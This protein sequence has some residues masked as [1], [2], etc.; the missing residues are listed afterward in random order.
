M[1]TPK[2]TGKAPAQY[3]S[4]SRSWVF[5]LN[6]YTPIQHACMLGFPFASY[7]C[8]GEEISPSGT[9]HLQGYIYLP[10]KKSLRQ[11]KAVCPEAHFEIAK[12]TPLQAANYCKKGD[13]PH[14]EW[15][16]HGINGPAFGR[17]AKFQEI[18]SAPATQAEKGKRG[19]EKIKL[20]WELAKQGK[21]EGILPPGQVK[22]WEYIHSKFGSTAT[23]RASLDNLWIM[24]KSGCGKSRFV[25]DT[26]PSF[27]SKP[28][29]KW[30]DG[31]SNEDVVVLDDFDPKHGEFLGYFLKIWADH[32]VFNAEVKGGMLR[33]RP[34]TVVVTSQ[35]S[36][37]QCFP[38]SETCAAVTRRFT[39]IPMGPGLPLPVRP[40]LVPGF[41]PGPAPT[42]GQIGRPSVH[43]RPVRPCAG[44]GSVRACAGGRSQSHSDHSESDGDSE[45]SDGISLGSQDSI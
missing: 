22:T 31:Y 5:T 38:D 8:I 40:S 37:A 16:E 2:K 36:I 30:W 4:Q 3:S 10:Q 26:F 20:M 32:Y 7:V 11:M 42:P 1:S 27:Y 41:D 18:G 35:Y 23:D 9:P 28:M 29:S 17:N 44:G 19:A 15:E 39:V 13:Q 6:N 25:R 43:H 45:P 24:G 12:G 33:I 34:K 14:S 21:I